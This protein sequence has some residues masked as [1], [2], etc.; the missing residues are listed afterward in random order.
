MTYFFARA[1]R[2]WCHELQ[3]CR[4]MH[5]DQL[6]QKWNVLHLWSVPG[7]ENAVSVTTVLQWSKHTGINRCLSLSTGSCWSSA[8]GLSATVRGADALDGDA[9]KSPAVHF[10]DVKPTPGPPFWPAARR[11]TGFWRITV[12]RIGRNVHL[13]HA[14]VL[15]AG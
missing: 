9:E 14:N 15:P 6:W 7:S 5:Q 10:W 2:Q 13:F 4:Q 12:H 11:L 3:S 1:D 8:A